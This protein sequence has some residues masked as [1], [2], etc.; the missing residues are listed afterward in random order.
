M[1]TVCVHVWVCIH[2]CACVQYI[3]HTFVHVCVC[4]C[5]C[6]LQLYG[7]VR[8]WASHSRYI[9]SVCVCVSVQ[10]CTLYICVY[11]CMS[12][13]HMNTLQVLYICVYVCSACL[14]AHFPCL[15]LGQQIWDP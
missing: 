4:V 11:V 9:V 15:G 7:D 13:Q 5:A 12:F 3:T 2:V 8:M 1:C 14:G 10:Y 6:A